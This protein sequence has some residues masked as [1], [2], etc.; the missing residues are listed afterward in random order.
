MSRAAA[1]AF[2]SG[3]HAALT[4]V[5]PPVPCIPNSGLKYC[6]AAGA[7]SILILVQSASSSS[8]RS[9]GS[10][11]VTPWP[12]SE[13]STTTTTLSLLPMR[14]HASAH[15]GAAGTAARLPAAGTWKPMTRPAPTVPAVSRNSRRVTWEWS[16]IS[17]SLRG[18][19]NGGAD[20]RI[21]PAAADVGHGRIDVG[22]GRLRVGREQRRR[23]LDL[24]RLAVAALRHILFDPGAL[25]RMG[26]GGR[27]AFDRGDV[28]AGDGG[29]G[30]HAGACCRS[31]HVHRARA[32]LRDAAA[33]FRAGHAKVV[34]QH[35]EQRRIGRCGDS[36]GAAV[37][38]EGSR[39]HR[40]ILASVG[41]RKTHRGDAAREGGRGTGDE[42]M[43]VRVIYASPVP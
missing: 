12:I 39:R 2:R 18:A 40:G 35:P 19:V 32:A 27:E 25:H 24:A 13:R 6:F 7:N 38:N 30:Q 34:A 20:A 3:I 5:L 33:E 36:A 26:A 10:E 11:V 28:L 42:Y 17:G 41:W 16:L 15:H 37:Q 23:G 4:L 8:A 29:H 43:L 1:P 21:G 9:M 22:I 31:V 14:S